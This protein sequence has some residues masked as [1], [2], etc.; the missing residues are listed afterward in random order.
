MRTETEIL[1][2]KKFIEQILGIRSSPIDKT[3]DIKICQLGR[4]QT[5]LDVLNWVLGLDSIE[6]GMDEKNIAG[7][8]RK[9]PQSSPFTIED[10]ILNLFRERQNDLISTKV[11]KK[12]LGIDGLSAG[13]CLRDLI[14][15]G[16]IEF[17]RKEGNRKMYRKRKRI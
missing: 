16:E 14:S 15:L 11:I 10:K 2:A 13:K 17:V 8:Y 5:K 9:M 6:A 3:F 12:V 7:V 1:G 4:L